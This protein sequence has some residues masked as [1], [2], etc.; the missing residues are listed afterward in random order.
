VKRAFLWA[1]TD[2]FAWKEHYA[3][4]GG[5]RIDSSL[6]AWWDAYHDGKGDDKV[7]KMNQKAMKV[8]R[9][10]YKNAVSSGSFYGVECHFCKKSIKET[11]LNEKRCARCLAS[12]CSE[13]CYRKDWPRHKKTCKQVAPSAHKETKGGDHAAS[14]MYDKYATC[15][16]STRERLALWTNA[17][18]FTSLSAR[19]TRVE[20]WKRTRPNP[21]AAFSFDIPVWFRAIMEPWMLRPGVTSNHPGVVDNWTTVQITPP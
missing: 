9:A 18:F 4:P 12:Y 10:A 20:M 3:K 7:R 15:T 21:T 5:G 13:D 14:L 6:C 17:K 11:R 2:P 8:Q 16:E 1:L 19:T